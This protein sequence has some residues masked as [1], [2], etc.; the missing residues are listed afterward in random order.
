MPAKHLSGIDLGPIIQKPLVTPSHIWIPGAPPAHKSSSSQSSI[1]VPRLNT[2]PPT[3]A[4]NGEPFDFSVSDEEC[5]D[6][7]PALLP[8]DSWIAIVCGVS[9]EQWASQSED[10][11]DGFFIAPKDVYMPDLTAVGDVL[12]GKLG[13]G[14]V[15]ECVDS[16]TPF[17]YVSRPLFI[18]E[19]GLR[20][21]LQ[22]EGVGIELPRQ[23]YE[24][25]DWANTVQQAW[26]QGHAQK[27]KKRRDAV[28]GIGL[29]RRRDEGSRMARQV[30]DWTTNWWGH[31][32]RNQAV[33]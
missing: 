28:A 24:D 23:S 4:V 5:D 20:L 21:Y 27:S 29:T 7:E 1:Q 10:L 14:T 31:T 17:V 9:K 12:L 25:G 6:V 8:D 13:Y 30:V 11:P 16:C 33:L 22:R 26:L 3:P 32:T 19:H 15:S 18:E 2:I